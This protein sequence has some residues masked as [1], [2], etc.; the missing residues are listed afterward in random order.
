MRENLAIYLNG[1]LSRGRALQP[2]T[3]GAT[4]SSCTRR[5]MAED[6]GTCYT[7]IIDLTISYTP[8]GLRRRYSLLF[9]SLS[10][11]RGVKIRGST[12]YIYRKVVLVVSRVESSREDC[13]DT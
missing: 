5:L 10:R 12:Y 9:F 11:A 13:L 4:S 1:D 2:R 8:D 6:F 3:R 7:S